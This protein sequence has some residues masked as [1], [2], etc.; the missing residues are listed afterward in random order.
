MKKLLK[1]PIATGIAGFVLGM[2]WFQFTGFLA[3]MF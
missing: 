2:F 3:G 1:N